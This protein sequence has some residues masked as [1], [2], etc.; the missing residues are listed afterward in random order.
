[1]CD[2]G[3]LV[4]LTTFDFLTYQSGREQA[5]LVDLTNLPNFYILLINELQTYKILEILQIGIPRHPVTTY[6]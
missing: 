5:N 2:S 4:L 6:D 1:M 3:G